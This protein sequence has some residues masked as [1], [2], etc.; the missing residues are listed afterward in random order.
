MISYAPVVSL[1]FHAEIIS[2]KCELH[3]VKIPTTMP[4]AV[5]SHKIYFKKIISDKFI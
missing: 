1:I 2:V 3:I 4:V 5:L